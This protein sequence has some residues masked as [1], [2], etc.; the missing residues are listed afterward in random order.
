VDAELERRLS[1]ETGSRRGRRRRALAR[2]ALGFGLSAA[3][4][5]A[6]SGPWWAGTAS[7]VDAGLLP[8]PLPT[9][10]L[11]S[12]PLVSAVASVASPVT[13]VVGGLTSPVTSVVGGVVSPPP[14]VGPTATP[15]PS[16]ARSSTPSSLLPSPAATTTT[17]PPASIAARA[18]S[19][20]SLSSSPDGSTQ[21]AGATSP[22][23]SPPAVPGP[24][25]TP[26]PSAAAPVS[27]APSAE[28]SAVVRIGP[29]A[30][31]ALAAGGAA[32]LV[33]LAVLAQLVGLVAW[34][35]VVRRVL[36]SVGV[37]SRRRV[38]RTS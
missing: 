26:D 36:G 8:L 12:V 9:L 16:A 27:G 31:P 15:T 14:I 6:G 4:L 7:R 21:P 17:G 34:I 11:P 38:G 19:S 5:A 3:L 2:I 28:P 10:S 32:L 29:F 22:A 25:A 24:V 33:A 20:P 1:P 35:P 30:V 37:G 13:S 23:M 18:S